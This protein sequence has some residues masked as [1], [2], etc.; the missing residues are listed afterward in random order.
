MSSTTESKS[1]IVHRLE[2]GLTVALEPLPYVHSVSIGIWIKTGSVNEK[3]AQAG[4]SHFLEHLLFKGTPT[5]TSRQIVE[6][7]EGRG[8]HINAFTSR[9]YTCVYARVLHEEASHAVGVLADVA[10]HS[11]F[12]DLEKE[13][14]VIL[15][16]I[17]SGEDVPEDYIHDVFTELLWPKHALGRPVAGYCKTVEKLTLEDFQTYHS[18]TY[19][20]GNMVVSV[21]GRFDP[22]VMQRVIE[23]A[24]GDMPAAKN[25][26]TPKAPKPNAGATWVARENTHQAHLCFGFPG[27][28]TNAKN[29]FTYDLLCSALGGGSTSRLFERIRED[30]G[31][32][33]SVYSFNYA[34]PTGGLFGVYA[35]IAPENLDLAAKICFEECRDLATKP[36][37]AAELNMNRELLKGGLLMAL[38]STFNRMSRMA[39]SLMYHDRLVP[40]QEVVDH[41]DAVT[42]EEITACAADLFQKNQCALT[43]LGPGE[44]TCEELVTL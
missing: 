1:A 3:A 41:I 39:K 2:N 29:R 24:M 12:N 33:Y 30:E 31:L 22:G 23:D 44:R 36:M 19:T 10:R 32:A 35:A 27:V 13:R 18:K 38:E 11:Q 5:R 17:A 25:P 37:K 7:I 42:A 16:E 14:N 21:A 20:P 9:E 28:T 8:G 34:Y 40:V 15:E 43:A 4:I 26:P 6:A